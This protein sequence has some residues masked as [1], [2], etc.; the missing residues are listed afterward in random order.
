M[1]QEG[2]LINQQQKNHSALV[3]AVKYFPEPLL[4][5]M[6]CCGLFQTSPCIIDS[7]EVE[8]DYSQ[9][10]LTEKKQSRC[11]LYS[12]VPLKS[13]HA[14]ESTTSAT[15]EGLR[16]SNLRREKILKFEDPN[17]GTSAISNRIKPGYSMLNKN[18]DGH[19]S[20]EPINIFLTKFKAKQ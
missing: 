1:R 8:I 17:G 16:L 13:G 10:L 7:G 11:G 4:E 18:L 5:V 2:C 19:G 3:L 12:S 15:Q 9:N 20:D 14:F 6:D